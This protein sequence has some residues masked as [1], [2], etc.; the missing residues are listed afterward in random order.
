[1]VQAESLLKNVTYIKGVYFHSPKIDT[2]NSVKQLNS[3]GNAMLGLTPH[4]VTFQKG[5]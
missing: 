5:Y 3:T 2:I 1:M 4:E